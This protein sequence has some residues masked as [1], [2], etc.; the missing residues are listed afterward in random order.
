MERGR[1]EKG[2]QEKQ[3]IVVNETGEQTKL[4]SQRMMIDFSFSADVVR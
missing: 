1:Q 3:N 4:C 2:E